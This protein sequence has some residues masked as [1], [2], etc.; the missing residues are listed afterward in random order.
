MCTTHEVKLT[1]MKVTRDFTRKNGASGLQMITRL[2]CRVKEDRVTSGVLQNFVVG[3][4]GKKLKTLEAKTTGQMKHD[5]AN[6][7]QT[8]Q[9]CRQ[10]QSGGELARHVAS[11]TVK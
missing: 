5:A 7:I 9:D 6:F 3:E 10:N 8:D 4:K 2:V 11:T 1:K